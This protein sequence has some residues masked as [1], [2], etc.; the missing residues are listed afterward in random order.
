VVSLCVLPECAWGAVVLDGTIGADW[1]GLG[2]QT[3]ADDPNETGYAAGLDIDSIVFCG[4]TT[5]LYIGLTVTQPPI[6]TDGTATSL[7]GETWFYLSLQG[8]TGTLHILKVLLDA[9]AGNVQVAVVTDGN[10]TDLT[11]GTDFQA[12]V[13]SGLELKIDRNCLS[14]LLDVTGFVAQLD[15][16]GEEKDD[17]IPGSFSPPVPEPS[18]VI[19]ICLGLPLVFRRR[20]R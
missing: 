12:G 7:L 6:D 18:A 2:S 19:L 14:S 13:G 10:T 16:T 8:D 11:N 3:F 1:D 5:D 9:V 15:G 20:R 17:Q 4:D